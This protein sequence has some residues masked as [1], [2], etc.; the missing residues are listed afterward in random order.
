[1]PPVGHSQI[2]AHEILRSNELDV[3]LSL[4]LALSTIQVSVR[5]SLVKFEGSIEHYDRWRYHLSPPPQFRMELKWREIFS[6]VPAIVIRSRRLS[7]PLDSTSTYS[8]CTRGYLAIT[9][10]ACERYCHS[11]VPKP[12]CR[13]HR[14]RCL[15]GNMSAKLKVAAG[16]DR[17]SET[18]MILENRGHACHDY[19]PCKGSFENQFGSCTL[20]K[21]KS[22]Q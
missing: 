13:S 2:E 20:G 9:V 17:F 4:T 15:R 12:Y 1:M 11:I 19:P 14:L 10:N 22:R 8:V 16:L 6:P 5:F 18:D 21:I 3:R 7:D